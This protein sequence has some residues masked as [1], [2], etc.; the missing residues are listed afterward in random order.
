MAWVKRV[1]GIC[2]AKPWGGERQKV[3]LRVTEARIIQALFGT[4][5]VMQIYAK[6]MQMSLAE[7]P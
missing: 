6:I 2:P 4:R 7:W 5:G 1:R 3:F